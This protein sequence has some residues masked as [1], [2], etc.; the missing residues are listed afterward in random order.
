[1]DTKSFKKLFNK[2]LKEW[3]KNNQKEQWYLVMEILNWGSNLTLGNE[4]KFWEIIK[5]QIKLKAEKI[6]V[7]SEL[8]IEYL[9][10]SKNSKKW[11]ARFK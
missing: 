9:F 10:E 4:I 7:T 3:N 11:M 5:N 2:K 1:M 6:D 8:I